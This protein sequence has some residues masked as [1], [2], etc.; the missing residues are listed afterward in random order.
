MF[1]IFGCHFICKYLCVYTYVYVYRHVCG[2]WLVYLLMS[3][4]VTAKCMCM[5]T[6]THTHTY[7]HTHTHTHTHTYIYIYIYIYIVT[8]ISWKKNVISVGKHVSLQAQLILAI[9]VVYLTKHDNCLCQWH[10]PCALSYGFSK[11]RLTYFVTEFMQITGGILQKKLGKIS[12]RLC[13]SCLFIYLFYS[14]LLFYLF[15]F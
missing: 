11:R 12:L 10:C 3:M 14:L 7:T 1:N 15:I 4:F 9:S 5:C 6:H 2:Y 13:F 8:V